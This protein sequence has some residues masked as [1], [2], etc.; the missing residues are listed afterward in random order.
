MHAAG[1]LLRFFSKEH[2]MSALLAILVIQMFVLVPTGG[3]ARLVL[4]IGE[5]LF[6]LILLAGIFSMVRLKPARAVLGTFVVLSLVTHTARSV[7]GLPSLI[8]WDFFLSSFSVAGMLV[9]ILRMVYSAGPVT[10]HRIRGS[11]A[12]YLLLGMLFAR[13]YAL[14][15]SLAPDAF[16]LAAAPVRF[17]AEHAEAFYYFSVVTLTTVGFGD[18]TAVAPVAR[19]FV[20]AEALI[21]QLYP[22]ILIARL[23]SLGVANRTKE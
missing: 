7:F 6:S 19:S 4:L 20:M 23:V 21:G 8:G 13:T 15:S 11:V 3:G 17:Q 1:R 5:T 12:G 18:I 22:A 9:V 16:N 2:S 10:A 14:I